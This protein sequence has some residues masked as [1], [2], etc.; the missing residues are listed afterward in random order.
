[1]SWRWNAGKKAWLRFHGDSPHVMEDGTQIAAKNVIFQ[2]VQTRCSG[3]FDVNGVCVEEI[4]SVGTGDAVV[5]RNG[6][7]VDGSW[8]RNFA[9]DVT[10]YLDDRGR[11]ID[12]TRGVTWIILVPPDVVVTAE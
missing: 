8:S 2:T 12:L 5:F 10:Q 7:R 3:F 9:E 4:G 6:K 11:P 1:M